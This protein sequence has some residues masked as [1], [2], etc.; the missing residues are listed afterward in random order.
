MERQIYEI[1]T[2]HTT[3]IKIT[4]RSGPAH[5]DPRTHHGRG[6]LSTSRFMVPERAKVHRGLL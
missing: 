2:Q 6:G 1:Y 3:Y 4:R 5:D